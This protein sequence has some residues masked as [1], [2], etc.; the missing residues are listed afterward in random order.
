VPA[1]VIAGFLYAENAHDKSA[2]F[3]EF[4]KFFYQQSA[5]PDPVY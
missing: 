5:H 4:L 1:R 3:T 2:G